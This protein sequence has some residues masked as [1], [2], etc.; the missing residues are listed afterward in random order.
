MTTSASLDISSVLFLYTLLSRFERAENNDALLRGYQLTGAS[1]R[2]YIHL[3]YIPFL[4]FPISW[5]LRAPPPVLFFTYFTTL[6][7]HRILS[8]PSRVSVPIYIFDAKR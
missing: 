1:L 8:D 2:L 7:P 4:S 5:P 3:N 6:R